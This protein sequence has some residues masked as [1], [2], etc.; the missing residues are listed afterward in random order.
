MHSAPHALEFTFDWFSHHQARWSSLFSEVGWD[1]QSPKNVLEIGCFEGRAS[2]WILQNLL[3]HPAS[4]LNC[5]DPYLPGD[6]V[7]PAEIHLV[8]ERFR[9]N[10]QLFGERVVLHKQLSHEALPKL[11][12]RQ[13]DVFDFIYIDGAHDAPTVLV[14]LVDS[15]QMLRPG[16]L[17]ICDDYGVLPD[18]GV[19]NAETT[20]P[21]LAID[22][23]LNIFEDRIDVKWP[24]PN[25]QV[26]FLKQ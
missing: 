4:R 3:C 26:A 6:V 15:F 18:S 17:I 2:I 16:G 1:P 7:G 22:A 9:R 19:D 24:P 10:V 23:F 11:R 8:E 12:A 21:K 20:V 13:E 25:Y 5:V 14:D